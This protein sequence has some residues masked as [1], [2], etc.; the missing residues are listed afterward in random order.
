MTSWNNKQPLSSAALD[1]LLNPSELSF[2]HFWKTSC[3][4]CLSWKSII[5]NLKIEN[6]HLNF[7]IKCII[8]CFQDKNLER[9]QV[10]YL[11]YSC[12]K[13]KISSF[14]WDFHRF[15]YFIL[16]WLC[17]VSAEA[18]RRHQITWK[19]SYRW[20]QSHH[21]GVGNQTSVLWRSSQRR[22]LVNHQYRPRLLFHWT[23]SHSVVSADLILTMYLICP[24]TD[25]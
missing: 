3:H 1:K 17:L 15:I 19:W 7:I 8:N 6:I 22:Y 20:L 14:Y 25:S 12:Y 23:G 21:V 2:T 5:T 11:Q 16:P 9:S 18:L 4:I 24:Q 13:S 10:G